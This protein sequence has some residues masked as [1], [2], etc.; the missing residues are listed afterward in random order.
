MANQ[1]F[2]VHQDI[3]KQI[4]PPIRVVAVDEN[5]L[6]A[7]PQIL[8]DFVSTADDGV[9]GMA[10]VYG[11]K[12]A[13]ITL[14][15]STL[16]NILLVR[17]SSAKPKGKKKQ[18]NNPRTPRMTPGQTLLRDKILCHSGRDKCAFHMD[19]LSTSLFLDQNVR[20]TRGVDLLSSSKSARR[21]LDAVMNA[22][23]GE[24]TLHKA[25][26]VTLFRHE[27]GSTTPAQDVAL[28]AWAACRVG[29]L[30]SLAK[31]ISKI[32]RIDTQTFSAQ[33]S[34]LFGSSFPHFL[35]Y[36][37]KQ[38]FFLA[39]TLRDADRLEALKPTR[40]KNDVTE[41][42]SLKSGKLNVTSSRF[43]TRI[44]SSATQ[45]HY[46]TPSYLLLLLTHL[47]SDRVLK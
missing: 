37:F 23:G 34:I 11:A 14:A 42:F 27:E 32:P 13:L 6:V 5:T 15:F 46:I 22:L 33:V 12:C 21:S 43:K 38:L 3:F 47:R 7:N 8:E 4:H 30:P 41:S 24:T 2:D 45:V 40:V 19:R 10:P 1:T 29:S 39:K 28:Q 44:M 18:K 26:M 17:F 25:H 16:H 35:M 31:T 20:I 36:L 9:I